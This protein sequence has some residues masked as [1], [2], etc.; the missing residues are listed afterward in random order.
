MAVAM[1][2]PPSREDV[3]M[4]Q[5]HLVL[6]KSKMRQRRAARPQF[7]EAMGT[8][9]ERMRGGRFE[10]IDA[11]GGGMAG[12][13]QVNR[14]RG[15]IEISPRGP[16]GV[17]W[18][19]PST[20]M[21]Q[22][23]AYGRGRA[24]D[25]YPS[26]P[27]AGGFGGGMPL[28]PGG[29]MDEFPEEDDGIPLVACVEC[30][31]KFKENRMEKHMKVCKKVFMQKRKQ[32]N[33]AANRLGDLENAGELIANAQKIDKEKEKHLDKKEDKKEDNKKIPEW[34]KKSL[35]FRAA[36]LAAK[37]A[38][39][40]EEAQAKANELQQELKAAV[41]DSVGP[42][43]LKCPHC[44]RTFNK[45]AGERH[46]LICVKTFGGKNGVG[47]LMKGGGRSAATNEPPPPPQRGA[48]RMSSQG[49]GAAQRKPSTHRTR[50]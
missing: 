28:S 15:G 40:D 3:R 26:Q 6:L 46:V 14:Q 4:A 9:A 11:H 48:A 30:G 7:S 13:H 43:M 41:G 25:G 29:G 45:E 2:R 37:A 19:P 50:G 1:M 8:S 16:T 22:E 17:T 20:S 34:K 36:M 21:E 33:S 35:A 10:P 42:D 5:S 49:G 24:D 38:T 27:Q 12:A 47:R 44:G 32:F 18:D 23:T 39:G 31:R